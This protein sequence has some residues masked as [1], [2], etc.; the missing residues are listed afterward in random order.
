ML[1]HRTEIAVVRKSIH[2]LLSTTIK[3][4]HV[5]FDYD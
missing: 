3:R 1:Y 5:P 4:L 2:T